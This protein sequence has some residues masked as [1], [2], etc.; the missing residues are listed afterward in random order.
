MPKDMIRELLESADWNHIILQLTHHASYRAGRYIRKP[1][2]T[3]LP[4][5]KSPAD[6]ALGAIE[7]VWTGI[8][9]WDPDKYPNL[10][11]HLMWIVDSDLQHLF[12]SSEHQKTGRMPEHGSAEDL[13]GERASDS[14]RTLHST[15]DPE[16]PEDQLLA[17]E[18][19]DLEQKLKTGLYSLVKGDQ[20]LELLLLC[21]EEGLDKPESIAKETGWEISKVYNLK[22]RL[23][24][25]AAKVKLFST[26]SGTSKEKK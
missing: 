26:G 1:R 17:K 3:G 12:S 21:F 9:S 25:T 14:E 5:G 8:R 24:R 22:K 7:K 6:V 2:S 15:F 20:D 23:L 11:T 10:L 16:T 4:G 13:E 19:R 18:E